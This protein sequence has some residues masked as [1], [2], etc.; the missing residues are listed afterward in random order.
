MLVT[1]LLIK[2]HADV[3]IQDNAGFNPLMAHVANSVGETVTLLAIRLQYESGDEHKDMVLSQET[4]EGWNLYEVGVLHNAEEELLHYLAE[5]WPH[6]V[7]HEK[8]QRAYGVRRRFG[9]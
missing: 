4:N 1:Q 7:R 5:K 8:L 3:S 2:A 6:L 9:R